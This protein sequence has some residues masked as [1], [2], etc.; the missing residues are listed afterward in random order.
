MK[1]ADLEKAYPPLSA[2]DQMRFCRTLETLPPPQALRGRRVLPLALALGLVLLLAATGI[3]LNAIYSIRE[4]IDPVFAPYV[5]DIDDLY[6]N[7]WMTLII[8]DALWDGDEITLAFHMAHHA[9]AGDVYVFPVLSAQSNG[10][11]L[12]VDITSGFDTM[13][14]AWLPERMPPNDRIGS[15]NHVVYAS[16]LTDEPLPTGDIGWTLT[17]HVLRP[18]WPVETEPYTAGGFFSP[19][20]MPREQYLQLFEQAYQDRKILLS[21]GDTT[22]EYDTMLPIPK[23][24]TADEWV[25][26]PGWERLVRSGA[27][28]EV[29]RFARH[30]T[31]RQHE[32]GH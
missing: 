8:K 31:T 20:P 6:Q 32:E 26:T 12:D 25:Y 9:G 3:A 1:L 2:E 7:E 19:L 4:R 22:L 21:F 14:G 29:D 30:F 28:A 24:M 18:L 16:I 17:F 10:K 11:E 15:N 27:F 23:G 5:T 13:D